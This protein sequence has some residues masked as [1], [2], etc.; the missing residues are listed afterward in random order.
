MKGL[1]LRDAHGKRL[2]A[3]SRATLDR[4]LLELLFDRSGPSTLTLE[5]PALDVTRRPDGS[6]DLADLLPKRRG[7]LRSSAQNRAPTFRGGPR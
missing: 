6:I 4:S 5:E 1:S 7:R 2:V 3:V